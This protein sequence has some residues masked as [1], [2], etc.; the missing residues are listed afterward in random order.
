MRRIVTFN[1]L[2]AD[3]YFAGPAGDLDWVVPDEEQARSPASSR[4]GPLKNP[5]AG[6][7]TWLDH[8]LN[9]NQT[10]L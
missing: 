1:W 4:T 5:L 6:L 8:S 2:T 10:D 3:G 9:L 7:E